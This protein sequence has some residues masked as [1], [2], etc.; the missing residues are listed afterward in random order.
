MNQIKIEALDEE[1]PSI[2]DPIK[3]D[4]NEIIMAGSPNSHLGII[5]PS[6]FTPRSSLNR[7]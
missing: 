2:I 6:S 5:K 7:S 1:A 3:D 4:S